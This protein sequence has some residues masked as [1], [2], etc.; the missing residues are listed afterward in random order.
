MDINIFL[1]LKSS[2]LI[3][4]HGRSDVLIEIRYERLTD[5]CFKCGLFGHKIQNSLET[6]GDVVMDSST[7]LL[8]PW[9][10][11][12]N[13]LIPNPLFQINNPLKACNPPT[14]PFKHPNS[15]NST[16]N[17]S[18]TTETQSLSTENQNSYTQ[19]QT[20]KSLFPPGNYCS[21]N[22]NLT[23]SPI[24]AGKSLSSFNNSSSLEL[25]VAK[26]DWSPSQNQIMN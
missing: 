18:R 24:L 3:P 7:T 6:S 12:E 20:W 21:G 4:C 10:K 23:A 25:H 16:K 13:P 1:P 22:E 26:P 11:A 14:N 2:V 9:I 5:F 8:G 15:Q 17:L 19:N